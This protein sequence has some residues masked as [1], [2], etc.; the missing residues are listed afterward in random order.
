MDG[1]EAAETYP[2]REVAIDGSI[3]RAKLPSGCEAEVSVPVDWPHAPLQVMSIHA[4]TN[5]IDFSAAREHVN[6]RR[7]LGSDTLLALLQAL[8]LAMDAIEDSQ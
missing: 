3:V 7:E 2:W 6:A 1:A 4:P 5:T 8:T